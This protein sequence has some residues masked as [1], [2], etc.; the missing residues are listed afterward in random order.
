MCVLSPGKRPVE[1]FAHLDGASVFA[2]TCDLAV[3]AHVRS[4][5]PQEAVLGRISHVPVWYRHA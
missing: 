1:L 3:V 5:D 2:V 4:D